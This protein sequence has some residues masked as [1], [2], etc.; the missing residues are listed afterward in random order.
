MKQADLNGG[1]AMSMPLKARCQFG[2]SHRAIR[3]KKSSLWYS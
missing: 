1:E 2:I 3:R